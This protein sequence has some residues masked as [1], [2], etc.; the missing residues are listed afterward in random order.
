M[1]VIAPNGSEIWTKGAIQTIL[2]NP[3]TVTD[4]YLV[5]ASTGNQAA[6]QI[7]QNVSGGSYSWQIGSTL[8]G[9]VPDGTYLVRAC[10]AGTNINT[11]QCDSSD[12]AFSIVTPPQPSVT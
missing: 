7:A 9:T 10:I 5:G 8:V 4:L 3:S 12:A 1:K 6:Y 2:W 11:G